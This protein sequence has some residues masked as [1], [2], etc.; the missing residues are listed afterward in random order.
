M[1]PDLLQLPFDHFQRYGTGA[2]ILERLGLGDAG[3]LEV[4][5]NRQ[6]LLGRFLPRARLLY[7]DVEVEGDEQ[8]FVVADATDMQFA[9]DSYDAVI[10]LDV[11]EHIP[12]DRRIAAVEEMARVSRCAVVIGCPLDAP[13]VREAEED[14]NGFWRE[15]FDED[16]EWLAEHKEF[17]LVDPLP[18]VE[19][20]ERSGMCVERV[21]QGDPALWARLMGVHFAKVKFPELDPVVA[22]LDRLYNTQAWEADSHEQSY[23]EYF[24][25][26]HPGHR[27]APLTLGDPQGLER[28][29]EVRPLLEAV[30]RGTRAFALRAHR[31]EASWT[32]TVAAVKSCSLDLEEAKSQW[33][34]SAAMVEHVNADLEFAK[35]EWGASARLV[36]QANA[37]L[38]VAKREWGATARLLEAQVAA[39]GAAIRE[40]DGARQDAASANELL[41]AVKDALARA[42]DDLEVAKRE[43]ALTAELVRAREA[44][45]EDC[46]RNVRRVQELCEQQVRQSQWRLRRLGWSVWLV[47]A[48]TFVLGVLA[49]RA[50][51]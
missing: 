20:F 40:R 42:H 48:A 51:Y 11:L 39:T 22:A 12:E 3:I 36:E 9:D 47:G 35:Q 15:L 14:A 43:W 24:V 29:R 32:A 17:G 25:A 10:S 7:T 26:V 23:R 13:W 8:D 38:E 5:A 19:A 28:F 21:R 4:G 49:S 37:D 44:D 33:G 46:R 16:Y 2:R 31:T 6:R 18:V 27:C 50:L 1:D 34:A 45:L 41:D 30:A